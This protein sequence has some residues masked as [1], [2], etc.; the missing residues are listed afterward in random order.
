[1]IL[2]GRTSR[3]GL[4]QREECPKGTSLSQLDTSAV[5]Q[6]QNFSARRRLDWIPD[7]INDDMA[8]FEVGLFERHA[9]ALHGPG[10]P[11]LRKCFCLTRFDGEAGSKGIAGGSQTLNAY[12]DPSGWRVAL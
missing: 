11:I 8:A 9:N 3:C 7:I 4:S 2:D 5:Q 10:E 12:G 6:L 1:M